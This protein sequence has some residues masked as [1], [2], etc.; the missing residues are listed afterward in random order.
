MA[1]SCR[2]PVVPRLLR[3][4][5]F[6][7]LALLS[8]GIV[9]P[10]AAQTTAVKSAPASTINVG[11]QPV[12]SAAAGTAT[13]PA[14]QRMRGTTNASARPPQHIWLFAGPRPRV[15]LP[16]AHSMAIVG[17]PGNS[18]APATLDQLYFSGVYPNYANSPLPN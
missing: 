8:I 6:V 15:H 9:T 17:T 12:T 1:S 16:R 2:F 11:N 10:A 7:P 18:A 5:I 14:P 3:G 4:L 13:T